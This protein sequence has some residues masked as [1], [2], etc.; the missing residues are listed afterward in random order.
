METARK[1]SN[2]CS[3][4]RPVRDEQYSR[5]E[6]LQRRPNT[7]TIQWFL[8]ME[9]SGQLDLD[10]PY[11]RRSVWNDAYRRFYVD[12][13]LRNYPSPAI[14]LQVETRPGVPT[15]Y[16]VIDGK[17]RLETLI[18]F[19]KD[20]FHLGNY[21]AAEGYSNPYYSDLSEDLQ[22]RFADYVLS[23]E[24]ISRTTP[25][26][27]KSAFERL[28]RNT[29][30]LNNQELR[31]AQFE[32]AFITKMSVLAENPLWVNLG[33]ASRAR[34]SRMLDVE[35]V[36]E[37]YLLTMHGILDGSPALLDKYYAEYDE[38]IPGDDLVEEKYD[39]IREWIGGLDLNGTRWT[40]LGDFYSL[41]AAVRAIL[42]SGSELP[43]PE[44]AE[45]M[46]RDF[47]DRVATPKRK[48]DRD[49]SDA[50]RQ[51][52]NKDTSRKTRADIVERLLTGRI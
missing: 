23:V 20:G 51:G 33:V 3:I 32:G 44:S 28:N 9:G 41:W 1:V 39:S 29:A 26:E 35:Y 30:K 15:V 42:E 36:S 52:T 17:Q 31:K 12:T 49:Y 8:E 5:G 24:N 14:Y 27:I 21:F 50:V 16:H 45:K 4:Q 2:R 11:Q 34:V 13:I 22:E 38:E 37:I 10:P 46:L 47:G 43:D 6:V 19:T 40:N 18:A 7:Q 25:D 48:V